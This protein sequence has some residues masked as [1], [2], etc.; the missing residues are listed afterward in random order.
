MIRYIT[1]AGDKSDGKVKVRDQRS[2]RKGVR[3]RALR[4]REKVR[5]EQDGLD[6]I[7]LRVHR[8][9]QVTTSYCTMCLILVIIKPIVRYQSKIL[10]L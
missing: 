2:K 3:Q 5:S 10:L 1:L 7:Q 9:I 4:A 6:N 8:A